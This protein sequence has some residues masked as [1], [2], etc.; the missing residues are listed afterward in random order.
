MVAEEDAFDSSA[1][2]CD[3][4]D[5]LA[6]MNA[7]LADVLPAF[8]K[9]SQQAQKKSVS[10]AKAGQKRRREDDSAEN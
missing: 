5:R 6:R 1:A 10:G 3:I 2:I 9:A 7:Q 4:E 8:L